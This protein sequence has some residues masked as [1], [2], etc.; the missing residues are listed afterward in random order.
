[1]YYNVERQDGSI[2]TA[3]QSNGD[4]VIL[5]LDGGN[6][7]E[8][9]DDEEMIQKNVFAINCEIE[10]IS[11]LVNFFRNCDFL[12]ESMLSH[13][14]CNN[15]QKQPEKNCFF[16]HMRSTYLRLN[17]ERTKGPKP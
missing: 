14:I 11:Y 8:S 10:E 4:L 6:D 13:C 3:D 17:K 16:C 5:Q 2:D 7:S 12:W 9:S 15:D 1:M